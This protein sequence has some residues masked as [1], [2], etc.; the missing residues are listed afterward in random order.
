MKAILREEQSGVSE[1]VGT[2][3]ILGMTVTLFSVIIA[4]V[5][6]FPSPPAQSRVDLTGTLVPIYNAAKQEIGINITMTHRGGESLNPVPT[7]IYVTD[8]VGASP[9]TTDVVILHKFNSGLINPNGLIDGQDSTWSV[10]ERWQYMNFNFRSGDQIT[11]T[12]VDLTRSLVVWSGPM[13]NVPG[14]RP[15]IFVN[16]WTDGIPSTPQTDPVQA[17]LGFVIH[18]EVSDPD[19]DLNLNSV[20]VSITAW[21]SSGVCVNPLPMTDQGPAGDQ[22]TGSHLFVL[23]PNVCENAPYPPLT[24]SGTFLILNAT[25]NAGHQSQ[26]RAVLYVV[27]QTSG[28]FNQTTIPSQLWQYIGFIQ[29]RT[30]EV[31]VSNLNNPVNTNAT[32]QP[33]RITRDQLNGNGGPLFHLKMANHGNTSIFVDGWSLMSFSKETSASVFPVNIVAPVDV[34]KPGNAGGLA[35]YP[36]SSTDPTNFQYSQAFDINPLNQ[37][38]GGTP[39][40][41]LY[42]SKT[43][44][45]SDW[46][47]SF[48]SNSYFINILISGMSGP[49]NYTV[50]M[51]KGSGPN[52]LNCPGLGAGYNP[53]SH[54]N[55]ANLAC[56]THWYAQV[57]P[58]IGMVVY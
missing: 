5:A 43:N 27:P 55:D 2:I 38:Q 45:K 19:G 25:D 31:W 48:V 41:L 4:W 46:P 8:Q 36:G 50:G 26:T 14:T 21:W 11:V 6:S 18:A 39:V 56:R 40:V 35:A 52:P 15:P 12:V 51:L 42:A 20:F 9:P 30:G 58:F 53:I 23:E 37:E 10:G 34:T 17:G 7:R 32:F 13:N 1:V 57:I 3:L 49:V 44:F 16:V 22:V 24:W 47:V 54:L 28:L 29:I 33:F